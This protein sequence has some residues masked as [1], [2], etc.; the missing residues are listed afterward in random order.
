MR[1]LTHGHGGRTHEANRVLD[2]EPLK[3]RARR[4]TQGAVRQALELL[5]RQAGDVRDLAHAPWLVDPGPHLNERLRKA[6]VRTVHVGMEV[7]RE[8]G[9]S[10]GYAGV[11]HESG[12]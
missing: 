11:V 8:D 6:P 1:Y 12:L 3:D 4:Q 2:A 10:S 5:G 7:N 9:Q